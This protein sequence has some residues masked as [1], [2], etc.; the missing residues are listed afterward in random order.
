MPAKAG[1]TLTFDDDTVSKGLP[2]CQLLKVDASTAPATASFDF[3]L[4]RWDL[5]KATASCLIVP[6]AHRVHVIAVVQGK[7]LWRPEMA[8]TRG[9]TSPDRHVLVACHHQH[10]HL[11]MRQHLFGDFHA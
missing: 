3:H 1:D 4:C 6:V 7:A 11:N 8:A 10:G 5:K 9:A 2:D